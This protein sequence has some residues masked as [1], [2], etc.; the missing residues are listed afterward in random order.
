MADQACVGHALMR[1]KV[2]VGSEHRKKHLWAVLGHSRERQGV[3]GGRAAGAALAVFVAALALTIKIIA[4]P[5]RLGV[6]TAEI[7]RLNPDAG[8]LVPQ[9][10]STDIVL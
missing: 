4:V 1:Q 3:N 5:R 2:R 6:L 8:G 9:P 10:A 7:L